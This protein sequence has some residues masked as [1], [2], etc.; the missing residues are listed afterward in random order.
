MLYTGASIH[1][2]SN[3][4]SSPRS[5]SFDYTRVR[6]GNLTGTGLGAATEPFSGHSVVARRARRVHIGNMLGGT[7]CYS[8]LI[9]A[10]FDL[11]P[12]SVFVNAYDDLHNNSG[13]SRVPLCHTG[14]GT[15]GR[16]AG[17]PVGRRTRA[18]GCVQVH[19]PVPHSFVHTLHVPVQRRRALGQVVPMRS[20]VAI[21]VRPSGRRHV[22]TAHRLM[23]ILRRTEHNYQIISDMFVGLSDQEKVKFHLADY[24]DAVGHQPSSAA[25]AAQNDAHMN[26]LKMLRFHEFRLALQLES[27]AALLGVSAMTLFRGLTQRT[28][29][30]KGHSARMAVSA[31]MCNL[32]KESLVHRIV[33]KVGVITVSNPELGP[34]VR[35]PTPPVS[36]LVTGTNIVSSLYQCHPSTCQFDT[37]QLSTHNQLRRRHRGGAQAGWQQTAARTAKVVMVM[38]RAYRA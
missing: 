34:I 24:R 33:W 16:S 4:D 17:V 10:Q 13:G 8:K 20:T 37:V 11:G 5:P 19:Q 2:Q 21:T 15:F 7:V 6:I 22:R 18:G 3:S 35:R 23:A 1:L 38:I 32:A 12:V 28:Q 27:A 30:V 31:A 25:A 29:L 26:N 36:T 9:R 14:V